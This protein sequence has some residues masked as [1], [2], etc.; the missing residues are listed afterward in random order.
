MVSDATLSD[1]GGWVRVPGPADDKYR[2]GVVGLA[3]GSARYPG[4]AVLGAEAALRTG[5][6]ML[7]YVG[8]DAAARLV[9]ARRPEAV[10]GVGRVQAWVLGSGQDAADRD[11]AQHGTI[12]RALGDA[13]D[14]G[15]PLVLDGG[16]IDLAGR[17]ASR[18][19]LT[20]HAGELARL[21][22]AERAD[23]E[24]DPIA[25]A[26]AAAASTGAVVLLK[27]AAT[28]AASPTGLALRVE[29]ASHWHG[30]AGAGDALAGVLGALLA[31]AHDRLD[32]LDASGRDDRAGGVS[33]A[34]AAIAA[35]AATLHARAGELASRGGPLTILDL[36]AELPAAVREALAA[37]G[38]G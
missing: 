13:R 24:A 10:V 18:V 37:A 16:A 3:T 28:I 29:A 15:V 12:D 9:L 35:A 2:R 14:R 38:R 8:D 21:T 26:A 1:A 30:T 4:A 17:G 34:L 20:P 6:G 11:D 5:V 33:D 31:G 27:G 36:C 32:E 25:A 22:G 19:V 7:R 23:I